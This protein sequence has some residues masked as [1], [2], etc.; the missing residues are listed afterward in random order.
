MKLRIQENTIRIRLAKSEI[1]L[2]SERGFVEEK[3]VFGQGNEF[4]YRVEITSGHS[5]LRALIEPF[6]II[7]ALP[8]DLGKEWVETDR[9]GL[10][11][12][13]ENE[14]GGL[15]IVIEKDFQCLHREGEDKQDLY[16]HPKMK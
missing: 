14:A 11:E 2:L 9:V 13:L 8:E 4:R 16:A 1:S 6:Q 3:T 5:Q 15:S 7:I 10:E 12:I